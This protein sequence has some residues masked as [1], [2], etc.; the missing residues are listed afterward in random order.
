MDG[1]SAF[2]RGPWKTL[3]ILISAWKHSAERFIV[4]PLQ[5]VAG[6]E[7]LI[8]IPLHSVLPTL[9]PGE[10]V[11]AGHLFRS[12]TARYVQVGGGGHPLGPACL[13]RGPAPPPRAH[14]GGERPPWV[15]FFTFRSEAN[16]Y[17]QGGERTVSSG[18]EPGGGTRLRKRQL[19]REN[20]KV[21]LQT[22]DPPLR[23]RH[24]W[25]RARSASPR[26]PTVFPRQRREVT[27]AHQNPAPGTSVRPVPG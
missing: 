3:K 5:G 14:G 2:K 21:S 12:F 22:S 23:L 8:R 18:S 19:L 26:I 7:L 17:G 1:K 4:K 24:R 20:S 16:G 10:W 25:E 13:G 6:D 9:I 27:I 11:W 15:R